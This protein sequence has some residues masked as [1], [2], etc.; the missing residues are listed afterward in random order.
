MFPGAPFVTVAQPRKQLEK[1]LVKEKMLMRRIMLLLA[2]L[3]L[4]GMLAAPASAHSL[5]MDP[6]GEGDGADPQGQESP[7]PGVWVGGPLL[8]E[9]DPENRHPGLIPG[10]P[11]G[12]FLMP[13]S[14]DGGLN[15]AC[16]SL[17]VNP[18]VVDIRGPGPSCP[19][20]Q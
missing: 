16:E 7:F 11:G 19:H 12:E 17:E 1:G 20:G 2:T 8:G 4:V 13:P 18:S 14:H 10:G 5:T 6:P 9:F 15:T 3:L